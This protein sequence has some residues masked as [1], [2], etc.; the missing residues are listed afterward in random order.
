MR[1]EKLF[2]WD[3]KD[4]GFDLESRLRSVSDIKKI[5]IATAYISSDGV[6]ILRR[7]A[8]ENSVKKEDVTLCL[9]AEFSD[10]HP[11]DILTELDKFADVRIAKG[12]RLFH[13]KVYFI[14][15]KTSNL[16][17]FGSSNLT[18]GGF[19]KNIEF[20]KIC[21]SSDE[22][23]YQAKKF[24]KYCLSQTD[25]LTPEHIE[26]Y[27]GQETELANLKNIQAQISKRLRGF[28]KATDFF[29]EITYDL[30]GFYFTFAD[31]ETFFLRNQTIDSS[32]IVDRRKDVREKLLAI[33]ENIE[34]QIRK[35]NLYVHWDKKNIASGIHPSLFN[36]NRVDWIGVRYGKQKKEIVFGKNCKESYERFTKH[37]NVQYSIDG[38]GFSVVLFFAVRN[39]AVDRDFLRQNIGNLADKINLQ[40]Q[41]MKG[42]NLVWKISGCPDF[43]FDKDNN[44]AAYLKQYDREGRYSYLIMRFKPDDPKIK[45]VG[46]ICKETIA[47][48]ELLKPLYDLIVWRADI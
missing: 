6:E 9:S 7:L 29:N 40:A 41:A 26:F 3:E 4:C 38:Y 13:A 15:G 12:G 31:Y 24:A 25:K 16:L 11:S 45:T 21:S 22:E 1:Y 28:E 39:E 19:G 23:N 20:D 47:G 14:E 35:L 32:K 42:H 43:I 17:M 8:A 30:S 18:R 27:K 2:Y 10:T 5:F 37:A 36:D 46:G 33:N 44:L 48:I 34:H